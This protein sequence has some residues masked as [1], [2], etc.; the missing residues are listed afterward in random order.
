MK[1]KRFLPEKTREF[2]RRIRPRTLVIYLLI[3]VLLV[4]TSVGVGY[5]KFNFMSEPYTASYQV[6]DY[7]LSSD[8]YVVLPKVNN[9]QSS[10]SFVSPDR[11]VKVVYSRESTDATLSNAEYLVAFFN[12]EVNEVTY[13]R[14][15]NQINLRYEI[16][17]SYVDHSHPL[18]LIGLKSSI[19]NQETNVVESRGILVYMKVGTDADPDSFNIG[20]G[21]PL[22]T[23]EPVSL[24]DK[25]VYVRYVSPTT[26]AGIS[27]TGISTVG[28][29]AIGSFGQLY[30]ITDQDEVMNSRFEVFYDKLAWSEYAD[31]DWYTED[32]NS[33]DYYISSAEELAGLAALVNIGISFQDISIYL[34]ADISLADANGYLRRWTPIGTKDN[35]FE[36]SFFG[37]G[38]TISGLNVADFGAS[39][40]YAAGGLF[41]YVDG[42]TSEIS[43]FAIETA[44]VSA[45]FY[46]ASDSSSGAI[47]SVVGW[48]ENGVVTDVTVTDANVCGTAKCG[49]VIAGRIGV[50][51]V[52][53]DSCEITGTSTVADGHFSVSGDLYGYQP[54][55][56]P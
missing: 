38:H 51:A 11:T 53:D 31:T 14:N 41:G 40:G 21:I 1:N 22:D 30:R 25:S 10:Y 27:K 24:K 35:P 3:A 15:S 50:S 49:G 12:P 55:A 29:I 8:N 48:L 46:D 26:N 17:L 54:T 47:G 7:E 45:E 44:Y 33:N 56:S 2:V 5:S 13:T 18:D 6:K 43:G 37:Q 20:A 23:N 34:D 39:G 19:K 9:P 28:Q 16:G 32:P 36:G 4:S 52:V 42:I